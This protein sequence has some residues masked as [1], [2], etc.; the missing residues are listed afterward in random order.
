MGGHAA[1][2]IEQDIG[3]G[4]CSARHE[5]LMKF[6]ERGVGPYDP[7]GNQCPAEMTLF[8]VGADPAQNQQ[9]QDEVFDEVRGLSYQ[10]MQ[11]RKSFRGGVWQ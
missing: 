7:D 5:Q 4:R 1:G 11:F 6:V 9:A 2:G 10:V 8:S 3:Q